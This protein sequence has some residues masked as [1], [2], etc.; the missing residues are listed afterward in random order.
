MF[1]RLLSYCN[2]E[3][4]YVYVPDPKVMLHVIINTVDAMKYKSFVPIILVEFAKMKERPSE[5]A[6]VINNNRIEYDPYAVLAEIQAYARIHAVTPFRLW[7][8][9][10]ARAVAWHEERH[11]QQANQRIQNPVEK[12]QDANE[13]ACCMCIDY[14]NNIK[15]LYKHIDSVKGRYHLDIT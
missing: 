2:D 15:D 6:R 1:D 14:I 4:P 8:E 11:L 12:E 13:F 10:C 7:I 5:M 9:T 3:I